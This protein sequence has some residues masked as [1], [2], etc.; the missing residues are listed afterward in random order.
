MT[1]IVGAR[2]AV[3]TLMGY[4]IKHER[5]F[6]SPPI[7]AKV[8]DLTVNGSCQML[9]LDMPKNSEMKFDHIFI[10]CVTEDNLTKNLPWYFKGFRSLWSYLRLH[11]P[12]CCRRSDDPKEQNPG[13]ER[14]EHYSNP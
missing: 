9:E 6:C 10:R 13:A 11:P 14:G 5:V 2:K 8:F 3:V 12:R 4:D 7:N 1:L